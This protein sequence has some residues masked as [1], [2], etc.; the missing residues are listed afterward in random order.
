MEKRVIVTCAYEVEMDLDC[1]GVSD[2]ELIATAMQDAHDIIQNELKN[3]EITAN[4]FTYQFV[5]I[6][7]RL[8]L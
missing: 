8:S 4:D 5:R 3:K 2:D 6:E 7:R 1:T